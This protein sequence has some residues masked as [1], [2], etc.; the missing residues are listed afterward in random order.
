[1]KKFVKKNSTKSKLK[2]LRKLRQA[3][4]TIGKL[5]MSGIFG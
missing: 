1:L 4:D 3:L 5:L 2:V